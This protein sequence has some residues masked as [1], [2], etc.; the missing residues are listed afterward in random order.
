MVP[1]RV[2]MLLGGGLIA[3][4]GSE[5]IQLGGAGPLGVVAAAFV[6]CYFWQQDGW[7]VEDVSIEIDLISILFF[8][9]ILFWPK[10]SSFIVSKTVLIFLYSLTVTEGNFFKFQYQ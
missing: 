8:V 6:S 3:V 7:D 9:S 10:C 2:L 4:L 5:E 1:L